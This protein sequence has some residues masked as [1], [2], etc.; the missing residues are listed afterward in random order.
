MK[1][2][3]K[4]FNLFVVV[5]FLKLAL[6]LRYRVK[7]K[8]LGKLEEKYKEDPKGFIFLP[9]HSTFIIDPLIL[10]TFLWNRFQPRPLT[11]D[12]AFYLPG[13]RFFLNIVK[14]IPVPN[15]GPSSNS[16]KTWKVDQS[17]QTVVDGLK[18]GKHFLFYPAGRVKL[19][20][21]E[22]VKSASGLTTILHN[23][24]EAKVVLIRITGFWGS[25]FSRAITG[26]LPDLKKEVI[27]SIWLVLKNFIFF[28]PK[29]DISIEFELAGEEFPY[30]EDRLTINN[31]LESWY[32]KP[33]AKEKEGGEPL[34]L[35]SS[36]FWKDEIPKIEK[37]NIEEEVNLE[38]IPQDLQKHIR[39]EIANITELPIE[40]ILPE[41]LL[42][43]DLCL[44]SLSTAELLVFLEQN[45]DVKHVELEDLTTVSKVIAIAA[46][47]YKPK[48]DYKVDESQLKKWNKQGKVCDLVI[49]EADSIIE[50]FLNQSEKLGRNTI[51]SDAMT[52][53]VSTFKEARVKVIILA[54]LIQKIPEKN[55][56]ILLPASGA[57]TL[58]V[59]ACLLA[60]KV[61]VMINWTVGARHLDFVKEKMQLET[62]LTSWQFIYKVSNVDFGSL[63]ELLF[64]IEEWRFEVSLKDKI[65]A[66]CLSKS[67]TEKILSKFDSQNIKSDDIAVVLF[68]SGSESNPKGVPLS[69]KNIIKNIKNGE[70]ENLLDLSANDALLAF[71]PPFHSFGFTLTTIYPLISGLRTIYFPNPTD[72]N[73]LASVLKDW[74]ASIVVGPPTFLRG[75]FLSLD[76]ESSKSVRLVVSGAEKLSKNVVNLV[77]AL[78]PKA[79]VCQG[80]GI[81]ECSPMISMN[82]SGDFALGVGYPIKGVELLIVHNETLEVMGFGESGLILV[83]GANVFSG[84]LDNVMNPFVTVNGKKWY[85]TGDIGYLDEKGFLTISGRLKRFVKIG[86]EMISLTGLEA[87]FLEVAPQKGWGSL[88]SGI[89]LAVCAKEKEGAK[90]TICLFTNFKTT[91]K[92]ANIVL[93]EQGFSSLAQITEVVEL[94]SIPVMGTGKVNYRYLEVLLE[95]KA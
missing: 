65:K 43:N 19:S 91:K 4:N 52:G 54:N 1:K 77:K 5:I 46:G 24:P 87:A 30:K 45:Y 20:S 84:Y 44:D 34:K 69:H 64:F 51:F 50:L 71:L 57:A 75:I 37:G 22:K 73:S 61:P 93:L 56:G 25:A 12:Y 90:P 35:V 83:R 3:Y 41:K 7:I 28:V 40:E 63:N 23:T 17:I 60:G 89:P 80:Y 2:L 48:K 27:K 94:E 21:R 33:F 32:N 39:E 95:N 18:K 66:F 53:Q 79:V 31:Y 9:N 14:A 58:L 13:A 74:K 11:I 36:S 67:K 92:A 88:D 68:T 10:S 49:P 86:G 8:G 15:F 55:I 82:L 70:L 16:H 59:Y 81:T 78:N 47:N 42:L 76:A 26:E 38:D 62:V 29:R 72:Y 6:S 85:N